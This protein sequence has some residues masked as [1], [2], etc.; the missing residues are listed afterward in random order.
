MT[1]RPAAAPAAAAAMP[2]EGGAA[3]PGDGGRPAIR[4]MA[5]TI[6]IA[7]AELARRVLAERERA[8]GQPRRGQQDQ[9]RR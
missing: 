6:G 1:A 2:A 4:L 3:D 5:I 9:R 7:T 8:H